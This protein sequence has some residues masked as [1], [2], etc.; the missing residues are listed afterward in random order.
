M[1][2]TYERSQPGFGLWLTT[3]TLLALLIR[4][5]FTL[6]TRSGY[7]LGG[8]AFYYHWQANL[9]AEGH[10]FIDPVRAILLDARRP[11]AFHPPGYSTFLAAVSAVGF[12]SV[13]AHRVA[14]CL[15]GSL[16]VTF[17]GLTGRCLRS[18]RV[19]ILAAAV[20]A[21]YAQLWINDAM[22]LSE[23]LAGCTIALA[24]WLW[25]RAWRAPSLGRAALAGAGLAVATLSR[26]EVALL[27]PA[28]AIWFVVSTREERGVRWKLGAVALTSSVLVLAPWTIYNLARFA[29]PVP[30]TTGTG[31]VLSAAS[32]DSTYEGSFRGWYTS[33][34]Q[35]V[36]KPPGDESQQDAALR[37]RALRYTR[38][39]LDELPAVVWARVG[40]LWGWYRPAQTT[41]LNG[42]AQVEGRTIGASWLGLVQSYVLMALTPV[43]L[44]VLRRLRIPVLPLVLTIVVVTLAAATSFGVIRYRITAEPTLCLAAAIAVDAGIRRVRVRPA[45]ERVRNRPLS[46][47][48]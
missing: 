40:R 10:G 19:G 32:C 16:T 35:A 48:T 6:V 18:P 12:R 37:A 47:A 21:V 38:S 45:P 11:S 31:S 14:S 26:S 9:L 25:Y 3:L 5:Y 46:S 17:I 20:A 33:C 2:R 27:I 41:R 44:L 43:G 29:E 24:L 36:K 1:P 4:L 28:L 39:H 13:T 15:L 7:R 22:L 23:S 42:A 8:D 34:Y 30:L